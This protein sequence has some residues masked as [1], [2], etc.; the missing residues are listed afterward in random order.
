MPVR[1]HSRSSAA[2]QQDLPYGVDRSRFD[3]RPGLRAGLRS[4]VRF[5]SDTRTDPVGYL[6][7][8]VTATSCGDRAVA[9]DPLSGVSPWGTTS[10]SAGG[11]L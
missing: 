7:G 1:E 5:E 2:A 6:S 8:Q 3:P 10:I 9:T 11:R 4:T